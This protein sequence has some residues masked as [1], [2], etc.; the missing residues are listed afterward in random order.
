MDWIG[1]DAAR[2]GMLRCGLVVSLVAVLTIVGAIGIARADNETPKKKTAFILGPHPSAFDV[3]QAPKTVL[4]A[5]NYQVTEHVWGRPGTPCSLGVLKQIAASGFAVLVW[6]CHGNEKSL[7]VEDYDSLDSAYVHLYNYKADPNFA[8]LKNN[9]EVSSEIEKDAQGRAQRRYDVG[10]DADG[11]NK[12]FGAVDPNRSIVVVLAC[13][14]W[15]LET[16]HTPPPFGAAE[17]LGFS[18]ELSDFDRTKSLRGFRN[19]G[20]VNDIPYRP[21]VPAFNGVLEHSGPGNTTLAPSCTDHMPLDNSILPLNVATPGTTTYETKMSNAH[22]SVMTVTGCSAGLLNQAWTDDT[23]HQ[24]Q[25]KPTAKGRLILKVE[26]TLAVSKNNDNWLIG[27]LYVQG[28]FYDDPRTETKD[29]PFGQSGLDGNRPFVPPQN[30]FRWCAW[31]G[32]KPVEPADPKPAKGMHEQSAVPRTIAPGERDAFTLYQDSPGPNT[33]FAA[34]LPPPNMNFTPMGSWYSWVEFTPDVSQVGQSYSV[35]FSTLDDNGPR[36]QNTINWQVV[37]RDDHV[38][39]QAAIAGALPGDLGTE[40][41]VPGDTARFDLLLSNPGN[42]VAHNVSLTTTDLVGPGFVPAGSI[43][44][45]PSLVG[46]L[47]PG[48]VVPIRVEV[49]VP[50]WLTGGTFDG[51]MTFAGVTAVGPLA[52]G[53]GYH[54]R[55]DHPPTV[56]AP[57]ETLLAIAGT[58]IS[59]PIGMS[60]PDGDSLSTFID[61]DPFDAGLE[62]FVGGAMFTWTPPLEAIGDWSFPICASDGAAVG[63]QE[64]RIHVA[65]GVGVGAPPLRFAFVTGPNPAHTQMQIRLSTPERGVASVSAYDLAGRLVARPVDRQ[66]VDVGDRVWTWQPRDLKSGVYFLRLTLGAHRET[67]RIVWLSGR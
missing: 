27:N 12:L 16:R 40:V 21:V 55:V 4:E 67:R 14:S 31:C 38:S 45:T 36:A 33:L 5:E 66:P 32:E 11:L 62:G 18:G 39:L 53:G 24:F 26:P 59:V 8:S 54:L 7:S 63:M 23:H 19:M 48:D 58:P 46:L 3:D 44:V 10:I 25:V 47:Q 34:T 57:V 61:H 50:L 65:G 15:E 22:P 60:D 43:A 64:L 13:D 51:S 41:V 30:P 1:I 56:S 2:R 42:T 6:I 28:D 49:P 20:G 9:I 37:P 52:G 35:Q 29:C 17:F